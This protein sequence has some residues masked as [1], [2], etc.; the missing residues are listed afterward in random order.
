[1]PRFASFS[2][3]CA[4]AL[5]LAGCDRESA[6]PAQ[7]AGIE[8]AGG[9]EFTGKIDRASAGKAIP[10]VEVTDPEGARLELASLTGKP[11]L[12]NLWATWC[13][14]CVTEMPLLDELA[15]EL[16]DSVTV[17]TVSQDMQGAEK[18]APFFAE[19]KFANLPQWMDTENALPPAFGGA[20]LPLTVLFDS[21]GKEVWRV[22][23]GFDWS[24]AEAR[25]MIAEA[26]VT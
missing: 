6:E 21:K 24:S 17:L 11:V 10:A 15:G 13:I 5:V 7:P 25:E 8:V 12:V 1:M 9:E 3:T 22:A 2:L 18:V 14:P 20:S 23:G 16:G 26:N 19:R 4:I